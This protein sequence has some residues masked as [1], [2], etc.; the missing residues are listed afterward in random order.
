VIGYVREIAPQRAYSIHEGLLNDAG[1]GL[2]D[3]VLAGLAAE[4]GS[5]TG[6]E[7]RRL[8]PGE[9]VDL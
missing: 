2:V 1:L 8:A 5:G 7:I 6:S 9:S 3:G 4:R